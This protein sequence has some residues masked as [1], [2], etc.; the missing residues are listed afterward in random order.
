KTGVA[1]ALLHDIGH[2]PLSHSSEQYFGFRHEPVSFEIITRPPISDIL[3]RNDVDPERVVRVLDHTASGKDTLLSQLISSEL[4]ADRL[5]Y[6]ARD[7]YF[8]GVGFGN[9]DLE[10]M[11]SMLRVFRKGGPLKNHAVTLYKGRHAVED[12]VLGRHLMY[13]AVYFH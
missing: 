13:Q 4:D 3:E 11:I 7:S 6:L 5:D 9:V 2:G 8:T 1:A 12:Y 10:R